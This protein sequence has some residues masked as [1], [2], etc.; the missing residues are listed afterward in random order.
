MSLDRNTVR[1]IANLARIAVPEE[2]LDH[3]AGELSNILTFVEELSS[4]DTDGIQ[5]MTSVVA[6][7]LP[8]RDDVVT[9]G[10]YPEK[11]LANA[12]GG[13]TDGFFTVPKVVE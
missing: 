3:L 4:A 1:T 13:A 12:P 5:P 9:D 10:G 2:D 7:T 11:V 6:M 8:M